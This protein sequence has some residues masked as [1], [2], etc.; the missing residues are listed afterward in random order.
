MKKI[1]FAILGLGIFGS[2]IAQELYQR[3]F[4]VIA[5]DTD[6]VKVD[7]IAS[8]GVNA[9][10]ADFTNVNSLK[11]IGMDDVD[12]GIVA[13]GSRLED[14]VMAIMNLKELGV[15]FVMAKARNNKYM[16]VLLKVGADKVI[17][18]EKEMGQRVARQLT[19][20]KIVDLYEIDKEYNVYEI[21]APNNFINKTLM[22]LDLRNK[23]GMNVLGIRDHITGR[24]KVN[25]KP[26]Y[27]IKN[28]DT[29]L[30]IAHA[31][32][33]DVLKNE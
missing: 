25:I 2:S 14:S 3:N 12:V 30:V 23:Y 7:K 10:Q 11:A 16:E 6:I 22:Q 4:E 21:K 24:L 29:L 31:D 20:E 5:I 33:L 26:D 17:I 32:F 27:V 1:T 15:P 9:Y 19:S 28:T 13:S 18:P 8:I